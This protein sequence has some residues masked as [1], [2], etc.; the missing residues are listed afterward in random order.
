MTSAAWV[1]AP[2]K[3]QPIKL[4]EGARK[5]KVGPCEKLDHQDTSFMGYWDIYS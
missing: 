1:S 4:L 2:P 3:S 5:F